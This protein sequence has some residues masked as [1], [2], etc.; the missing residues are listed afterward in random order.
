MITHYRILIVCLT[1]LAL[2]NVSALGQEL[3]VADMEVVTGDLSARTNPR[4]DTNGRK[5]ALLK[6][7]V[8]DEIVEV[9][10]AVVGN[11]TSVGME[12]QIYMSHDAKRVE[13]VFNHHFPLKIQFDNYNIP[14]LTGMMTYVLKLKEPEKTAQVQPMQNENHLPNESSYTQSSVAVH[15]TIEGTRKETDLFIEEFVRNLCSN[16]NVQLGTTTI[17]DVETRF[18]T[19]KKKGKNHYEVKIKDQTEFTDS[20]D[21]GIVGIVTIHPS[22]VKDLRLPNGISS[23]S[24]YKE[25][26]EWFVEHGFQ[27]QKYDPYFMRQSMMTFVSDAYELILMFDGKENKQK[28]LFAIIM[29]KK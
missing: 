11:V 6:V 13:F 1:I 18:G 16:Y 24:S 20:D 8:N 14:S 2:Y 15:D 22:S 25:W 4:I 5:C 27:S 23:S 19:K 9:R 21:N 29:H 28:T 10:G 12:K 26:N 17:S 7:Y 3:E